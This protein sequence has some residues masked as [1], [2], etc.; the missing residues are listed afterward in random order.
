MTDDDVDA[1]SGRRDFEGASE[2][3]GTAAR[4]ETAPQQWLLF[5]LLVGV[6]GAICQYVVLQEQSWYLLVGVW[7]VVLLALGS[8]AGYSTKPVEFA[9]P[10][11]PNVPFQFFVPMLGAIPIGVILATFV[12][13][14]DYET[15]TA[16]SLALVL[17]L[18]GLGYVLAANAMR[19]YSIRTRDRRAFALGGVLLVALGVAIAT[20]DALHIWGYA[21]F[22]ATY[23]A[24]SLAAYT[25]LTKT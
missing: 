22:G 21:A 24:Y 9:P 15:T 18:L 7:T 3:A 23:V 10:E 8:F 19:S 14:L 16:L 12:E 11:K 6:G 13:P 20:V 25:F 4:Y 1:A 5:G 2:P 17:V